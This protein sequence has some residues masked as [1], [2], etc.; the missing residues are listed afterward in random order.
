MLVQPDQSSRG[1]V[2]PPSGLWL[3]LEVSSWK[4]SAIS[5]L[6]FS[7]RGVGVDTGGGGDGTDRVHVD[8]VLCTSTVVLAVGEVFLLEER[9]QDLGGEGGGHRDLGAVGDHRLAGGARKCGE[10]AFKCYSAFNVL[11]S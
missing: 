4:K 9:G 7:V 2:S 6:V 11:W 5:V 1:G 3:P 8:A 10:I